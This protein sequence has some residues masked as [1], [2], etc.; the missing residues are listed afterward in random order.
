MAGHRHDEEWLREAA[1]RAEAEAHR[2]AAGAQERAQGFRNWVEAEAAI[3]ADMGRGPALESTA[4]V[5]R[6]A[7]DVTEHH[8]LSRRLRT[9]LRVMAESIGDAIGRAALKADVWTHGQQAADGP[10]PSD[11]LAEQLTLLLGAV[12]DLDPVPLWN[13]GP[14]PE[15]PLV[16]APMAPR[17]PAR[18]TTA[19]GSTGWVA[20]AA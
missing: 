19:P 2:L 1:G 4:A 10:T 16:I 17:A 20:A 18:Q 9:R 15:R 6:Q 13:T 12:E 14:P 7:A 3:G 11:L 8:A 5:L